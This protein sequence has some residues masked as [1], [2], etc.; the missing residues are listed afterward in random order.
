LFAGGAGLT[1]FFIFPVVPQ[2]RAYDEFH[3]ATD[4][5]NRE[6]AR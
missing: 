6:L 4:A 1:A 3:R 2:S 5:Y